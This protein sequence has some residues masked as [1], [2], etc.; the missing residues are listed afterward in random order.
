AP[1]HTWLPDAHGQAPTPVSVLLSGALLNCALYAL[2]RFHLLAVGALGPDFSSDLLLGLGLLSAVVAVPFVLVQHDLKRLLAYSSIEHVGIIAVALGIGGPIS[3]FG[4]L[5]HLVVH[6]LGKA[7][8]FF[9][10]GWLAQRYGTRNMAR[11]H[12]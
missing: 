4:G 3:L 7:A 2:L 9:A 12:G 5:L 8:L 6:A 1:M 11:I 10:A